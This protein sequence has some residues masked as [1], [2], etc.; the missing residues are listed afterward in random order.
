MSFMTDTEIEKLRV[1]VGAL[2]AKPDLLWQPKLDFFR[3]YLLS[4]GATKVPPKPKEE[5]TEAPNKEEK[6]R[7]RSPKRRKSPRWRSPW[8]KKKRRRRKWRARSSWTWKALLVS[9]A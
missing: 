8:R 1:F 2:Q 4:M 5:E 9:R 6:G 3:D 7:Q